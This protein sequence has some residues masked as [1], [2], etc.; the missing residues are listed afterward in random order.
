LSRLGHTD[1]VWHRYATTNYAW[2]MAGTNFH[3]SFPMQSSDSSD[4]ELGGIGGYNDGTW[5]EMGLMAIPDSASA[6]IV[7]N[8]RYGSEKPDIYRRNAGSGSWGSPLLTS[9]LP[10]RFTNSV[11][12]G[13]RYEYQVGGRFLYSAVAAPPIH[14]RGKVILVVDQTKTN[15]IEPDLLVL[16]TN[17]V[18]EGWSVVRTNVAAAH[19]DVTWS[20]NTNSIA[21][22][23][24]F[25]VSQYK[26]DRVA[27]ASVRNIAAG[28]R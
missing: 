12:V 2:I 16:K 13:Q 27:S 18:G 14:D 24:S 20:N 4:L 28:S 11:T 7:L 21:Q 22:I 17:L 10:R 26:A 5:H 23:K 25:I 8:W 3:K 1:F 6:Q 15:S 9:S 19:D